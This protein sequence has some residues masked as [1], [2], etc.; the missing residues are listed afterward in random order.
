VKTDWPFL[1]QLA[2]SAIS[3][4]EEARNQAVTAQANAE[5]LLVEI[6]GAEQRE[7]YPGPPLPC[8][9][10]PQRWREETDDEWERRKA[11]TYRDWSEKNKPKEPI[12]MGGTLSELVPNMGGAYTRSLK[13]QATN[14]DGGGVSPEN[15]ANGWQNAMAPTALVAYPAPSGESRE[16]ALARIER[17]SR[18]VSRISRLESVIAARDAEIAV[19]RSRLEEKGRRL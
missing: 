18:V 12:A 13:D 4:A 8:W 15:A 5:S 17:E 6:R 11:F 10:E 1:R 2:E 14:Q 3:A 19:L 9:L 7:Q 16:E